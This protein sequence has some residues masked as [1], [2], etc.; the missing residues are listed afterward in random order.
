MIKMRSVLTCLER[1]KAAAC[2]FFVIFAVAWLA[3][4][5]LLMPVSQA[6]AQVAVGAFF[7]LGA[8]VTLS[9][10]TTVI[11]SAINDEDVP[12]FIQVL[13]GGV[14]IATFQLIANSSSGLKATLDQDVSG[15]VDQFVSGAVGE[16][17]TFVS[18]QVESL[19]ADDDDAGDD[20]DT[21]GDEDEVGD[22]EDADE[23]TGADAGL[24]GGTPG[25]VIAAQIDATL[26]QTNPS[27]LDGNVSREF[28][29]RN[30]FREIGDSNGTS[31]LITQILFNRLQQSAFPNVQNPD[32]EREEQSGNQQNSSTINQNAGNGLQPVQQPAAQAPLQRRGND[33][34]Q[35]AVRRNDND[36]VL[37]PRPQDETEDRSKQVCRDRVAQLEFLIGQLDQQ[38]AEKKETAI[39][40]DE[41][42][43]QAILLEKRNSLKLLGENEFF[44]AISALNN[45]AVAEAI[46]T[47]QLRDEAQAEATAN[48]T[49]ETISLEDSLNLP[50]KD[51]EVPFDVD[52]DLAGSDDTPPLPKNVI[53]RL[54]PLLLKKAQ[55]DAEIR[56]LQSARSFLLSQTP[57]G[58]GETIQ[59][60]PI[61]STIIS[62]VI[63]KISRQIAEKQ[64][65]AILIDSE[66]N[67]AIF[68]EKQNSLKLLG[69]NE[70]FQA[71][72]ELNN[73]VAVEAIDIERLRDEVQAEATANST[74]ETISLEDSLNLPPKDIEVPFDV[75]RDLAGSDDTPPLPKNVIS[76][77]KLFLLRKAQNDAEIRRLQS[78][79]AILQLQLI[80]EKERCDDDAE[81]GIPTGQ[82]LLDTVDGPD[83][84]FAALPKPT[85][86]ERA[87]DRLLAP[88]KPTARAARTAS[89]KFNQRFENRAKPGVQATFYGPRR[90]TSH[91]GVTAIGDRGINASFD[92][93]EWR[94]TQERKYGQTVRTDAEGNPVVDNS[95][96]LI[97]LPSI[98]GDNRFN[99]FASSSATIGNS[100]AAGG[101]QDSVSYGFS[102]GASWLIHPKLNIGLA[103]R[104][105]DGDIDSTI[106]E[107]DTSTWGIAAFAQTQLDAGKQKI[108][109]EGIIAYSRSD[110]DS[111]FNNA[112]V[113]TTAN[114]VNT[115]AFST[116]LSASTSFKLNKLSFS[117]FA[118][119]S[120]I[121]TDRDAFTV[122]DGQFQ[123]G[124][125]DDQVIFSGGSSLSGSFFLPDTEILL[126]PS[127][128]LG[129]FGTVADNANIGLSANGGL[130][131]T[132]K[133]GITSSLGVGFSGLT[134]GTSNLSFS[135]NISI[136]I[137]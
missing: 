56:R 93:R 3:I 53:S 37:P 83:A 70:F 29:I 124:V 11:A 32:V 122:S 108:N 35:Q 50:P 102:G 121:A 103:G 60:S 61:S 74:G 23:D 79:K 81:G 98:F 85:A 33:N 136:P 131:I 110:V 97:D 105:S 107:I 4:G 7:P 51:I 36:E 125:D 76:R 65:S 12:V 137:N 104:Y 9:A 62:P 119:I 6:R 133:R 40:I 34:R 77:L 132:T 99:L 135:G 120:Y 127:L 48:S 57:R 26:A 109:L 92:L 80:A 130:G 10:G 114:D 118:S 68:F 2:R 128:A 63:G 30:I 95:I 88:T 58:F 17:N 5:P 86:G 43:D 19:G 69:E 78:N 129:F 101:D 16:P 115:T 55:N 96:P 27:T 64:Q 13:V 84:T 113:I 20:A 89:Q 39:K 126:S 90:I 123:N 14:V 112:G 59:N 66:V 75:D 117:P 134:G 28:G 24:T 116:Q 72:H 49:G 71:I 87:I 73:D 15:T 100:S 8:N 18:L 44:R 91:N 22:D 1:A 31:T 42:A 46:V 111:L 54:K 47:E 38:I 67:G 21:G 52:R 82:D 41:D 94:Q 106:S 45:D 25:G